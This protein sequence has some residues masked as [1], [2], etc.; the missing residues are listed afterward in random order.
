MCSTPVVW[1]SN[2]AAREM[3]FRLV[4]ERDFG[5]TATDI[6]RLHSSRLGSL[7]NVPPTLII[8]LINSPLFFHGFDLVYCIPR[9]IYYIVHWIFD[10]KFLSVPPL[11]WLNEECRL[12]VMD[13]ILKVSVLIQCRTKRGFQVVAIDVTVLQLSHPSDVLDDGFDLVLVNIAVDIGQIGVHLDERV[14]AQR[15][16]SVVV[17]RQN[18]AQLFH[19]FAETLLND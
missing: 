10:E 13:C 17:Q 16:A 2:C 19:R 6:M 15:R 8:I 11:H 14:D 12:G 5:L 3:S 18:G 9:S 1:Q 7:M 4:K